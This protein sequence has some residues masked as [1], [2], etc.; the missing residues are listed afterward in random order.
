MLS[1]EHG[2]VWSAPPGLACTYTAAC[3]GTMPVV[4]ILHMYERRRETKGPVEISY[5]ELPQEK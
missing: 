5:E 4:S 1:R 2:T 3:T